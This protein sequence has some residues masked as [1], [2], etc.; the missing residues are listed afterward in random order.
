MEEF[1]IYLLKSAICTTLFF[2]IY[3]C[4]L[5][6][7]TFYRFNRYFLIA[8]VLSSFLLPFL[9][10]S[11]T[12]TLSI[13]AATVH[14]GE[15]VTA[16]V[17]SNA[18][19]FWLYAVMFGYAGV[20]CL[21]IIR[22]INGLMQLKK[23][24]RQNS[25]TLLE[26]YKLITTS[27]FKSSFS[28]FNYIFIAISSD[29][30]EKEKTLIIA[31]ELAHVKQSHWIDLL[32]AQLVCA[33]QWFNPFAWLYLHAIK[34][35]HEFLADAAVLQN[36]NSVA[37]YRAALLNHSLKTPVFMFAS[38]F[39]N[40]D[41]FK[42]IKMMT[43]ATSKPLKKLAVLIVIPALALF[44]FAFAKPNY[45]IVD[46]NKDK[47]ALPNPRN[48]KPAVLIQPALHDKKPVKK[49]KKPVSKQ[50]KKVNKMELAQATSAPI[51]TAPLYETPTTVTNKGGKLIIMDNTKVRSKENYPLIIYNGKTL[52]SMPDIN[53]N[54]INSINVFKGDAA[55]NKY[56][57][58]GKNGVI[59]IISKTKA[60]Q[61]IAEQPDRD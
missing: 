37:V 24:I 45:I 46:I 5:K 13:P 52:S 48:Q 58:Q 33:L 43:K 51:S 49:V 50:V 17:D 57:E 16:P 34:E 14:S 54:E 6:N 59:E 32:L 20:A 38:S 47:P 9:Q 55:I 28:V 7:E 23:M 15:K 27:A 12:V 56:G 60:L 10:Y 39:G 41:Q 11:Y 29:T 61:S 30:S 26:G 22:H 40:Y 35:N 8:G 42:R 53:N 2:G 4:F 31:H 19:S 44:L 1:T 18:L 21:L 25:Y 36:G 3:W